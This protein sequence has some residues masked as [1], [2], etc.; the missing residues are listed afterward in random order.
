MM[1]VIMVGVE[2]IRMKQEKTQAVMGENEPFH[3]TTPPP[4]LPLPL[5][6]LLLTLRLQRLLRQLPQPLDRRPGQDVLERRR[7]QDALRGKN[8]HIPD[9]ALGQTARRVQLNAKKAS[10]QW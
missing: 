10:L 6:P 9:G 3:L 8:R 5:L 7:A 1:I 4:P 2:V